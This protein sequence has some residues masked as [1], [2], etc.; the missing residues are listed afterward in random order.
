MA[1]EQANAS[2]IEKIKKLFELGSRAKGNETEAAAAMEK[3]QELVAKYNLDMAV[4]RNAEA[5]NNGT[6]NVATARERRKVDRSAQYEWQK[7]LW[8]S[9]ADCNFCWHFVTTVHEK[10][11]KTRDGVQKYTKVKRH[12]ILGSEENVTFV[13][14]MGEYLCDTIERLLPWTEN[15]DRLSRPAISWRAGCAARLQQRLHDQRRARQRESEN[16]PTANPG[17]GLA[18]RLKDVES[19]EYAANYDHQ[20]GEGA[21]QRMLDRQAAREA[22]LATMPKEQI[23]VKPETA[24]EKRKRQAAEERWRKQYE[25]DR[26]KEANRYDRTAFGAGYVKGGDI[27]LSNQVDK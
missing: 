18:I 25:R 2:V 9:L 7:D 17:T 8:K 23:A 12:I 24:E 3:A 1:N 16:Q 19:Q 13:H 22:E 26:Q 11:G 10:A 27:N 15:K 4:I 6:V 21:Y 14:M 20:Y 5:K